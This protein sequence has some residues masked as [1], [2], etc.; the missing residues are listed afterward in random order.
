MDSYKHPVAVTLA[1]AIELVTACTHELTPD[2]V[3]KSDG[4]EIG[5]AA[6]ANL[7]SARLNAKFAKIRAAVKGAQTK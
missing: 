3:K 2:I 5:R 4:T 6:L 1:N 7:V